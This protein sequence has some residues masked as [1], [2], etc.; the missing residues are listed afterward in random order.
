MLQK[1]TA[2]DQI[3]VKSWMSPSSRPHIYHF[4]NAQI[5]DGRATKRAT[6]ENKYINIT[7]ILTKYIIYHISINSLLKQS[8]CVDFE[9]TKCIG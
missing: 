9:T 2:E 6:H 5:K 7:Y 4:Q 8:K 3:I 1:A